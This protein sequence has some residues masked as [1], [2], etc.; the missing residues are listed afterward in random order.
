MEEEGKDGRYALDVKGPV[1]AI[2][3]NLDFFLMRAVGEAWKC[4]EPG[5]IIIIFAF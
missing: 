4:F 3:K 5:Y 1:S 2:L